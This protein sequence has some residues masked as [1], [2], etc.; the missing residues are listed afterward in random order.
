[1]LQI[2]GDSNNI[3]ILIVIV[4]FLFI[5]SISIG[6]LYYYLSSNTSS[7]SPSNNSNNNSNNNSSN[8]SSNNSNNNSSSSTSTSTP[9][10]VKVNRLNDI[11]KTPYKSISVNDNRVCVIDNDNKVYCKSNTGNWYNKDGCA[12]KISMNSNNTACVTGCGANNQGLRDVF[13][14]NTIDTSAN[15][16]RR[17]NIY[18]K[19]VSIDGTNICLINESNVVGC[20]QTLDPTSN[21]IKNK[22]TTAISNI[23]FKGNKGC[24]TDNNNNIY[25][26]NNLF[27]TDFASSDWIKKNGTVKNVSINSTK[28]CIVDNNNKI[29]CSTNIDSPTWSDRTVNAKDNLISMSENKFCYVK[30]T[31]GDI[32]CTDNII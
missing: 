4:M 10:F 3:K 21:D 18:G 16:W 32:Y 23:S 27:K 1:M 19:D 15:D 12:V 2:G 22:G 26:T 9:N 6:V 8:N 13:C 24:I 5:I 7:P 11:P 28:G 30:D 31:D 14:S 29:N 20:A 17:L 25:C